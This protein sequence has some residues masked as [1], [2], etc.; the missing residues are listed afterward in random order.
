M[1]TSSLFSKVKANK[2]SNPNTSSLKELAHSYDSSPSK[3]KSR[4]SSTEDTSSEDPLAIEVSRL[5]SDMIKLKST[6][7]KSINDMHFSIATM[8][9]KHEALLRFLFTPSNV[10]SDELSLDTLYTVTSGYA[11]YHTA[12]MEIKKNLDASSRV[13]GAIAYNRKKPRFLIHADDLLILPVGW[14][15]LGSSL[16]DQ[17]YTS[18]PM[19]SRFKD[20][21][22]SWLK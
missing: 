12:L 18:L 3:E 17:V 16:L 21:L 15:G 5:R 10:D 1:K 20:Q 11:E 6:C 2:E 4:S 9:M 19:S 8:S 7:D 22:S 14:K 13:T